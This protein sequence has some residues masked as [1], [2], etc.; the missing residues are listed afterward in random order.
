MI[1]VQNLL[2]RQGAQTQQPQIEHNFNRPRKG[3]Q[4]N[5]SVTT[6]LRSHFGGS[7]IS[8]ANHLFFHEVQHVGVGSYLHQGMPVCD[9]LPRI[10]QHFT[11]MVS[12]QPLSFVAYLTHADDLIMTYTVKMAH[13]NFFLKFWYVRAT[14]T[15]LNQQELGEG[16]FFSF[17][18]LKLQD[19]LNT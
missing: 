7:Y 19:K 13:N 17:P 8:T 3:N 9:G 10:R 11:P 1:N 16:W 12:A 14:P 18:H 2:D 6:E 5:P 15:Q 4:R